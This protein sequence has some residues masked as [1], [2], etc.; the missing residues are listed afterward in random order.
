MPGKVNPTQNEALTMV[1]CQVMGNQVTVSVAGSNG[2]FEV[3]LTVLFECLIYE[4]LFFL[5]VFSFLV[6]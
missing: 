6:F 2:H 3:C 1:C 5:F 4:C